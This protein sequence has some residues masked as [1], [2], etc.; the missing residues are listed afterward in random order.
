M[1]MNG[2]LQAP[3]TFLSGKE[4]KLTGELEVG[5]A[6]GPVWNLSRRGKPNFA[7]R[8]DSRQERETLFFLRY[9]PL[10]YTAVIKM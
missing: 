4:P 5:W 10:L 3:V 8:I 1:E 9:K 7:P 2:Q 6:S